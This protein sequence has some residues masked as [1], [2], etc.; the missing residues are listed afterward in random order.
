[1]SSSRTRIV[2]RTADASCSAAFYE[3]LLGSP[4]AQRREGMAVFE[5]E[6][7]PLLLIVEEQAP[8][9]PSKARPR[10]GF[11]LVVVDPK[12]VGDAAIRLRRAGIRLRVEDHGIDSED[13]DG[14]AWQVRFVPRARGPAVVAP[15]CNPFSRPSTPR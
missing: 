7:P 8:V 14:N 15:C 11:A 2:V 12:H 6:S 3:A 10:V 9:G 13:P 1:M 5:L 4:P